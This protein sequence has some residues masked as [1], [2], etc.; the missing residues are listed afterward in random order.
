MH[1]EVPHDFEPVY[2]HQQHQFSAPHDVD[3]HREDIEPVRHHD[4][5][6]Y[7]EMPERDYHYEDVSVGR[8]S[9]SRSLR[10]TSLDRRHYR[11]YS[12]SPSRRSVRSYRARSRS[13]TISPVRYDKFEIRDTERHLYDR[14]EPVEHSHVYQ[15][16][17]PV[18]YPLDIGHHQSTEWHEVPVTHESQDYIHHPLWVPPSHHHDEV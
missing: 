4:T 3:Y 16:L 14:Y 8:R 10:S 15:H 9:R 2:H 1:Y 11:S 13:R 7:V 17:R 5:E 6:Y 18:V 12:L